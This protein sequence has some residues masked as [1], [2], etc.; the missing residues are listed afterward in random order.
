M[1]VIE[2]GRELLIL[3]RTSASRPSGEW[4]D[5]DYD[6]LASGEVVGRI[7]KVNAAPVVTRG[8]GPWHSDTM[9]IARRHTATR[10]LARLRWQ[11]SPRVGGGSKESPGCAEAFK[12]AHRSVEGGTL[13]R[14]F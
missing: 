6:V 3:K 13:P 4:N 8:C 7:F 14:R 10:R 5:D 11:H 1:A 12:E 9:R 2:A